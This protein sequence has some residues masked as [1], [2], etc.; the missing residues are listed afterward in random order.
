MGRLEMGQLIDVRLSLVSPELEAGVKIRSWQSLTKSCRFA[1]AE[2]VR[3][4]CIILYIMVLSVC[5]F[6]SFQESSEFFFFF[7][8]KVFIELI[9]GPSLVVSKEYNF[10]WVSLVPARHVP[11][12]QGLR[13]SLEVI[14]FLQPTSSFHFLSWSPAV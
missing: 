8:L 7:N 13:I 3:L 1:A 5:I 4:R 11:L 6:Q 9:V 10:G 2:V 14:S 12:D